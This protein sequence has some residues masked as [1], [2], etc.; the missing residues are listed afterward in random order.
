MS[1]AADALRAQVAL[2]CRILAGEGHAD[3]CFGHVSAR[4]GDGVAVKAAGPALGEVGPGHVALVSAD[5]TTDPPGARL[6][7]EMPIHVETLRALPHVGAVVHTHPPAA[8]AIS[9]ERE[10]PAPASQDGLLVAGRVAIA[11]A[12]PLVATAADGERIAALLAERPVLLLRGHG[13]VVCGRDVPEATVLAVTL[14]RA[15]QAMLA[16][17][18]AGVTVDWPEDV[19]ATR[20]ALEGGGRRTAAV[21][22]YLARTHGG[23]LADAAT[24]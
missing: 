16:A 11:D 10:L 22:R 6:H 7:E 9:H 15:C 13:I 23:E 5:G 14:E 2:A 20:A 18:T 17:R 24:A 4:W 8:V 21:W 3:L 12:P 19:E 1:G